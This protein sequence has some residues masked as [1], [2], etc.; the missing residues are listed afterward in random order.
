MLNHVTSKVTE[1]DLANHCFYHIRN[2]MCGYT[3]V[4]NV[5]LLLYEVLHSKEILRH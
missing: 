1:R 4:I 3:N 2:F 5:V